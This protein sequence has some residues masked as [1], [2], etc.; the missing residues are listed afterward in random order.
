M[1]KWKRIDITGKIDSE[2]LDIV[3]SDSMLKI[4]GI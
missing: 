1:P 2:P 3:V 4:S